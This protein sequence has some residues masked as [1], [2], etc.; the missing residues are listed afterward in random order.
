MSWCIA[1][2][3]CLSTT[4]E[5]MVRLHDPK[6][7]G[8]VMGITLLIVQ[9]VGL[10]PCHRPCHAQLVFRHLGWR[11]NNNYYQAKTNQPFLAG[12]STRGWEP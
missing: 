8:N 11:I 9:R 2:Y 10:A 3:P 6:D 1:T 7:R 12:C 4:R 5:S